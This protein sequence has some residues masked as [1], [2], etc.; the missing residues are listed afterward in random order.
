MGGEILMFLARLRAPAR[1]TATAAR[2]KPHRFDA[3]IAA[4]PSRRR[5]NDRSEDS[6]SNESG[7]RRSSSE[8]I[9]NSENIEGIESSGNK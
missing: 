2:A 1:C 4:N 8:D 9:E 7:S 3:T 6:E 5:S